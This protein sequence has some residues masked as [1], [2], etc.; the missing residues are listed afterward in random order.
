MNV[1]FDEL[2]AKNPD[3]VGWIKIDGTKVN[4]PV[5]QAEDNDYYLTRNFYKKNDFIITSENIDKD[6]AETEYT[7]TWN[8]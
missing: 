2:L 7:M 4:Y 1:N 5:V 6:T 8:K 3:T